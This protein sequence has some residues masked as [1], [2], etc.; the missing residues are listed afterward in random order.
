MG[1][2][3]LLRETAADVRQ[4]RE[5]GGLHREAATVFCLHVEVVSVSLAAGGFNVYNSERRTHIVH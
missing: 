4:M 2:M 5:T 1:C 3:W